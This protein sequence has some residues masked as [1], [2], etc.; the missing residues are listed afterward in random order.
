MLARLAAIVAALLTGVAG[1][2]GS[3]SAK[4]VIVGRAAAGGAVRL[5]YA[6][7]QDGRRLIEIRSAEAGTAGIVAV[8]TGVAPDA[9]FVV[10]DGIGGVP[11]AES[12]LSMAS[13][14]VDKKRTD[15]RC[16]S[17]A[18]CKRWQLPGG[19]VKLVCGAEAPDP[20]CAARRPGCLAAECILEDWNGDRERVVACGGDS[21][22]YGSATAPSWCARL[23]EWLDDFE[24]HNVAWPWTRAS[25]DADKVAGFGVSS[26]P[27]LEKMLH[28][29]PV[30]DIVIL[31]W[32]TNDVLAHSAEQTAEAIDVLVQWMRTAGVV[33]IVA[34]IP[35]QLGVPPTVTAT[36]DA[37]NAILK[38]RYGECLIDF[39]TITPSTRSWYY[40]QRHLNDQAQQ[41]RALEAY[42]ALATLPR[43]CADGVAHPP[44]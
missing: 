44:H 37:A 29:L 27:I 36:I 14:R 9:G 23:G 22:T 17:F 32:G 34:T 20:T 15:C 39:T 8:A 43:S 1:A 31:P 41:R 5:A 7:Q 24:V 28:K 26:H 38:K 21:N 12:T 3:P 16:V 40:D 13:C 35:W 2:Y 6:G 4:L 19:D 11:S 18:S 25:D 30:P 42:Y 10:A 33:P